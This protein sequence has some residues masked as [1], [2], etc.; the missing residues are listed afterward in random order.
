MNECEVCNSL[1]A[2]R[3][4]YLW[5][6]GFTKSSFCGR[7][8]QDNSTLRYIS[9]WGMPN[10]KAGS[11]RKRY[12]AGRSMDVDFT[13]LVEVLAK[14]DNMNTS[15]GSRSD[16][17]VGL[18][19]FN[20]ET[21]LNGE[22]IVLDNKR[23][24]QA[25]NNAPNNNDQNVYITRV[26]QDESTFY[27]GSN[28]DETSDFSQENV[29]TSFPTV[30][31]I[32]EIMSECNINEFHNTTDV[33]NRNK[34]TY[35]EGSD[36][37]TDASPSVD[38]S[39]V[40]TNVPT[41]PKLQSGNLNKN[42][43]D[44][45]NYED[46]MAGLTAESTLQRRSTAETDL[47]SF[48]RNV[49]RNS[50]SNK[51]R[52]RETSE[53]DIK[54][55]NKLEMNDMA[56]REP[57]KNATSSK[58]YTETSG[59]KITKQTEFEHQFELENTN[60]LK[61]CSIYCSED[62]LTK[63][64]SDGMKRNVSKT[65]ENEHDNIHEISVQGEIRNNGVS[66]SHFRAIYLKAAQTVVS[67]KADTKFQIDETEGTKTDVASGINEGNPCAQN[68]RLENTQLTGNGKLL[69]TL[70]NNNA[71]GEGVSKTQ[72]S[73]KPL[74]NEAFREISV[75]DYNKEIANENIKTPLVD[76]LKRTSKKAQTLFK[77]TNSLKQT[78]FSTQVYEH[79][80]DDSK[81][82][83]I[84]CNDVTE[85]SNKD[86]QPGCKSKTQRSRFSNVES[87]ESAIPSQSKPET[88][89][90]AKGETTSDPA[91]DYK[92]DTVCIDDLVNES[93]ASCESPSE[94]M[95]EGSQEKVRKSRKF[96]IYEC[97]DK[98]ADLAEEAL[99][100]LNDNDKEAQELNWR[101]RGY[102]YDF[103]M[104]RQ[105]VT[106]GEILSRY[107]KAILKR[108]PKLRRNQTSRVKTSPFPE[109][110]HGTKSIRQNC[111]RPSA[112]DMMAVLE[113]AEACSMRTSERLQQ[114]CDGNM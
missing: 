9:Y 35:Y 39:S 16:K 19:S 1:A 93:F 54:H 85:R 44:D 112:S 114:L 111:E 87:I 57:V 3:Q 8:G 97:S 25:K 96:S 61:T 60:M 58:K 7:C 18:D 50:S 53:S 62:Q 89:N 79:M 88:R 28:A 68:I 40:G 74:Q 31:E 27:L 78:A 51:E 38:S 105:S 113:R 107:Q 37:S 90:L 34:V 48:V 4:Y 67:E 84:G 42:S 17:R 52:R 69:N 30:S 2:E 109:H 71:T 23:F 15:M 56:M 59:N 95:D 104:S 86:L 106:G 46:F 102:N 99:I 98:T 21:I 12:S 45:S 47:S 103:F 29:S 10:Y 32:T 80:T 108:R 91:T 64:N 73:V 101:T 100:P 83:I 6:S 81:S 76:M 72:D 94:D 65:T 110:R 66:R 41:S 20:N 49:S 36:L 82:S 26:L 5:K 70:Y 92:T 14:I 55:S 43:L 11:W 13:P 63:F 22:N 75:L 24:Y 77:S 33:T